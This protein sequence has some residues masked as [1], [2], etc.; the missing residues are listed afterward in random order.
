MTQSSPLGTSH[1]VRRPGNNQPI[2]H[3]PLSGSY[4]RTSGR[5]VLGVR[6]YFR[7]GN[8]K[9]PKTGKTWGDGGGTGENKR[10]KQKSLL[11]RRIQVLM[12]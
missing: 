12:E 8:F 1:P 9:V 6:E 10:Q 7:Q 5:K 4:I 3:V 11:K 2:G